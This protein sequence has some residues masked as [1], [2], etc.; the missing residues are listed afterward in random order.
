LKREATPVRKLTFRATGTNRTVKQFV[1][2]EGSFSSADTSGTSALFV[3]PVAEKKT[4][5]R[6]RLLQR[7]PRGTSIPSTTPVVA[8]KPPFGGG[9]ETNGVNSVEGTVRVGN[10]AERPFRAVRVMP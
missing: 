8:G 1:I 4:S 7:V 5:E 3:E 6:D 10:S 9:N 2:V